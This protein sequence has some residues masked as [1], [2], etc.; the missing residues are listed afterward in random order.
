[1]T[2]W[3]LISTVCPVYLYVLSKGRMVL[4]RAGTH[5]EEYD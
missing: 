1:M 2:Q 5:R 3:L 4:A